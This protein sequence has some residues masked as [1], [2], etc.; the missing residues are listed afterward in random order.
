MRVGA[1]DW[2][3]PT[4]AGVLLVAVLALHL[5]LRPHF[6]ASDELGRMVAGG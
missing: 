1:G 6:S 2:R 5:F 3:A 4:I